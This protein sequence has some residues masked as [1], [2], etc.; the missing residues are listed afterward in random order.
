MSNKD[1]GQNPNHVRFDN[2]EAGLVTG[3]RSNMRLRFEDLLNLFGRQDGPVWAVI[4]DKVPTEGPLQ[5]VVDTATGVF[6][7]VQML[8]DETLGTTFVVQTQFG[9]VI[10]L[11]PHERRRGREEFLEPFP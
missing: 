3:Q 11:D 7:Y 4:R 2:R 9:N 5:A 1:H 10:R 6:E 8:N